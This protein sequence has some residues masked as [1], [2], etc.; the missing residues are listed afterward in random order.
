MSRTKAYIAIL[1]L[2]FAEITIFKKLS[3]YRVGPELLL[4]ATIFFGLHF[5]IMRGIEIGFLSGVLK[6]VFSVTGLGIN[7]F[8]FILIGF[9]AGLFRNKLFKENFGAQ[10]ILSLLSVYVIS[11]IYFIYLHQTTATSINLK[12]WNAVLAK[13]I[14]TAIIAPFLFLIFTKLF[15]PKEI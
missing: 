6:D 9:L 14:Y 8:S 15:A 10:F 2:F 5:G 7:L 3:I 4:I 1:I 13:G 11:T 12:L